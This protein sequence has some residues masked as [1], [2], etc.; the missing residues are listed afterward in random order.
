MNQKQGI[1]RRTGGG[2]PPAPFIRHCGQVSG[3]RIFLSEGEF[4]ELFSACGLVGFTCV[5]YG[6]FVM[7]SAAKPS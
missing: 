7:L 6:V 5:R 3:S 1:F 4:E 2:R